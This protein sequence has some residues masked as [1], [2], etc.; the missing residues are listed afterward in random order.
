MLSTTAPP[1]SRARRDHVVELIFAPPAHHRNDQLQGSYRPKIRSNRWYLPL[2]LWVINTAVV[3]AYILY[4]KS[5]AF[6]IHPLTH[7]DF[8]K[9]LVVELLG[10]FSERVRGG[11]VV[12]PPPA[13][14]LASRHLPR[15]AA[16]VN[17]ATGQRQVTKACEVCASK[18]TKECDACGV[19][20]CIAMKDDAQPGGC[21]DCYA[22]WHKQLEAKEIPKQSAPWVA[23]EG[24]LT[25]QVRTLEGK[26]IELEDENCRLKGAL[27][28]AQR[29]LMG[30]RRQPL[31]P[32][33][34]GDEGAGAQASDTGL[35]VIG[36]PGSPPTSPSRP[37]PPS[38]T[39]PVHRPRGSPLPGRIVAIVPHRSTPPPPPP[40]RRRRTGLWRGPPGVACA[41]DV[42][43]LD[44]LSAAATDGA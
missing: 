29:A 2:F 6:K 1:L 22:V 21:R 14:L 40:A 28:A 32:A 24:A 9:Q 34:G 44:I 33:Q 41:E 35:T 30:S 3:Q 26:V 15:P 16:W 25:G 19:P 18:T 27:L 12:P 36:Q 7:L 43:F 5:R 20:L 23:R 38:T 42:S 13:S 17:A 10:D 8:R 4:K 37:A 39:S 31:E 11:R